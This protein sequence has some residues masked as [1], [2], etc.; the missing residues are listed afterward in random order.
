MDVVR[1]G[2]RWSGLIG[3]RIILHSR[4]SA[5]TARFFNRKIRNIWRKY[6]ISLVGGDGFEP[7]TLSV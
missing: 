4:S 1:A 5:G 2:T 6:L 3:C 7:P